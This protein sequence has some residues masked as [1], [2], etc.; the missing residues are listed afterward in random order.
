MPSSTPPRSWAEID[1]GAVRHNADVARDHS[2]CDVMP[3]VKA[4]AYGHGAVQ[5]ARAMSDMATLYGVANLHEAEELRA[6][7]IAPPILL[8][9]A[10]LP[11][12]WEEVLRQGFHLCVST[13]EEASALDALAARLGTSAHVHVVVDTGMGRIGFPEHLWNAEVAGALLALRHVVCEGFASHLPSP[14]DDEVFTRG[15]IARFAKCVAL[16]RNAGLNP[17]WV[18]TASGAGLL[19]YAEQREMCNLVR[20]GLML[21]GVNPLTSEDTAVSATPALRS[22]MTWK[23]RIAMIRRLPAGHGI[24]YGRTEILKQPTTVATLACGYADGYPRQVSGKGAMV[25]IRGTRCALLG[26]VTMDQIMV[27]VTDL[28][29]PA[30]IGDEV[31]LMGAQG[32]EFIS[33]TELAQKAGT[34]AWH[35]FTGITTR[36][37]RSYIGVQA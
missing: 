19:G 18:H 37:E 12:E 22:V 35:V 10:C 16:A 8:L 29:S 9:S 33:A 32:G 15:Q 4:N 2:K 6:G 27:D 14:D 23:T 13:L 28:P 21:Y 5:V 24:S 34:I 1:L 31:V 25:L 36:V 3:I 17:R 20:P 11:G 26:R 30:A 7:G